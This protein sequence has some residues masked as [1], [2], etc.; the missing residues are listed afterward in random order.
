MIEVVVVE[1]ED[2]DSLRLNDGGV[3][4]VMVFPNRLVGEALFLNLQVVDSSPN[5]Q[6]VVPLF[7][8][9]V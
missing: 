4:R 9:L 3:L 6:G 1:E 2:F 7:P 5:Q 8:R